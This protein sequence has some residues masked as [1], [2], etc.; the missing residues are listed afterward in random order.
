MMTAVVG[1]RPRFWLLNIVVALAV[2][3]TLRFAAIGAQSFW[4]DEAY[5]DAFSAQSSFADIFAGT[6]RDNGNPPLHFLLDKLAANL[7]GADETSHRAIPAAFGTLSI[8]LVG[9]LGR[10]LHSTQ[11]GAIAVWLMAISPFQIELSNEARVYSFLQ[12]MT[13]LTTLLFVRWLASQSSLDGLAYSIGTGVACYSHYF[14]VFVILSH[15]VVVLAQPDRWRLFGR[16]CLFMGVAAVLWLPWAPAFLSQISTPGNLSRMG[17]T[18]KTQFAATPV[19]FAVGRTFAWRDAGS[20]LLA[21]GAVVSLVGFWIPFLTCLLRP[22]ANSRVSLP[23]LSA[24]VLLP[25]LVPLL[26]AL[27]GVPVYHH[28]YGS[29]GLG[30]FLI[31]V[32]IGLTRLPRIYQLIAGLAII[33]ATTYS[34]ANY[35]GHYIK[36]DWR[37]AAVKSIMEDAP[38]GQVVLTDSEIEVVSFL[39]Y[40]R[41]F[42]LIPR[43]L[44]ALTIDEDRDSLTGI[45]YKDGLKQDNAFRNY[46]AEIMS[47]PCVTVS[48]CVSVRDE[49]SY[50]SLFESHGF[51]MTKAES[52][53]RV[54]VVRFEKISNE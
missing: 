22:L 39:Y 19:V 5:V 34:L 47:A 7:F 3:G 27:A 31:A 48:L 4:Y 35:Y 50:R 46:S 6:S 14:F 30:G 40:A 10:R 16:W 37:S 11:A 33:S 45:R 43:E 38:P 36:D 41:R 29:V 20:G 26:A 13:V 49:N 1:S 42:H 12:F 53:Y 44:Y 15:L 51:R 18:W 28:R 8:A 2:G 54:K 25:I 24:W 21:L 9:L 17:P 32:A 52:F 23:L